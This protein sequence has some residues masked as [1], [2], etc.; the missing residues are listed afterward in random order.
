MIYYYLFALLCSGCGA[1]GLMFFYHSKKVQTDIEREYTKMLDFQKKINEQVDEANKRELAL[2]TLF[3]YADT[4]YKELKNLEDHLESLSNNYFN[5]IIT[6]LEGDKSMDTLEETKTP[7]EEAK[8]PL[9]EDIFYIN[10]K[11]FNAADFEQ[12]KKRLEEKKIVLVKVEGR[13]YQTRLFD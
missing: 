3:N 9:E 4:R 12:E 6:M 8:V 11:S 7:L 2:Q 5:N 1:L 10:E 13:K